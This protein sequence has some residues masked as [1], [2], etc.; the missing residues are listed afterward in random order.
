MSN[1]SI[2]TYHL[3]FSDILVSIFMFQLLFMVGA[4]GSWVGGRGV[5]EGKC[6]HYF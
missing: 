4:C 2:L 1:V 3:S 6:F 5:F